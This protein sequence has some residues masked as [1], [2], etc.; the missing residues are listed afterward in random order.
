M[1]RSVDADARDLLQKGAEEETARFLEHERLASRSRLLRAELNKANAR[2]DEKA[3]E[4]ERLERTLGLYA[5][6]Y[7]SQKPK[8]LTPPRVRQVDDHVTLVAVLSDTHYGEVIDPR[9]MAGSNAYN[10][11]I[12][13]KR[14]EQFFR[15]TVRLARDYFAGVKYDGIV[16]ALAGDLVSG[17]IHDELQQTNEI[18]TY[19][20][21]IWAVPRLMAGIE[22]WRK[23][24]GR[25]HVVS[26]PGN[27]GRDNK[28]PRY[29]GRSA[30]N[31][32]THIAKMIAL[33][34]GA[35]GDVT[36]EIPTSLDAMFSVYDWNFGMEHGDELQKNFTG[37][38]EI[39]WLGPL[40][41]GTNRKINAYA[42]EGKRLDYCI[43][44]HGHQLLPVP[45]RGA[46]GNGSVCGTNEYARGRKFRPEP[47]QQA[48]MVVAPTRGITLQAPIL[49]GD[50][51][52]EGW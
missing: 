13:E 42:A 12:A 34:L 36:F 23:E 48:L 17:D 19:D 2:L 37:S 51:R 29:K 1:R 6:K 24:F 40:I 43:W 49:V 52:S 4:V 11:D 16:L 9:Q 50:R 22:M 39:G 38:A 46:I 10:L 30:H 5:K 31:A 21:T 33:Q 44:A 47:P 26:A 27:H 32:D 8:W 45:G 3:K 35:S 15:R 41:R 25:V 14:T 18:D 28:V 7:E 20:T